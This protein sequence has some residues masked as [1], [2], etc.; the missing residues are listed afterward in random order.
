MRVKISEPCEWEGSR[1]E[2]GDVIEVT[3]RTQE[4]NATWMHPTNDPLT[5]SKKEAKEDKK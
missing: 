2:K 3:E 1:R 4:L 5:P